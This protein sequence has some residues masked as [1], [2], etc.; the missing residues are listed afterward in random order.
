MA[1]TNPFHQVMDPS[2]QV[3][4]NQMDEVSKKNTEKLNELIEKNV[5]FEKDIVEDPNPKES[6]ENWYS[7]MKEISER[8]EAILFET[9]EGIQKLRIQMSELI[10]LQIIIGKS[11]QDLLK[12]QCETQ[13]KFDTLSKTLT[14]LLLEDR[15][16]QEEQD[17]SKIPRNKVLNSTSNSET[18]ESNDSI[19]LRELEKS[20]RS[21]INKSHDINTNKI[22]IK[23][24]YLLNSKTQ[25]DIWLDL[26]KSELRDYNLLEFIEKDHFENLNPDDIEDCKRRVRDI[27]TNRLDPYYHKKILNIYEPKELIEKLIEIKRIECNV[28]GQTIR[29]K[30]YATKKSTKESSKS[31]IDRFDGLVNEY[32]IG[33]T[34]KMTEE[35]KSELF[36][37]NIRDACPEFKASYFARQSTNNP[38][39]YEEMKN[40]LL[41]IEPTKEKNTEKPSEKKTPVAHL[42]QPV[43]IAEIKCHR[44]TKKGHYRSDCPLKAFNLWFCYPCNDVARHTSE[45]CPNANKQ[46][47]SNENLNN[48]KQNNMSTMRGRERGRGR[49]TFR[50]QNRYNPYNKQP[51]ARLAGESM[52]LNNTYHNKNVSFIADSGATEHIVKNKEILSDFVQR[53]SGEI[54]C[55]NKNKS[56]NIKIN[57]SGK[58][59]FI[60]ENGNEIVLWNV[61]AANSI[62]ENLLSLRKFADAGCGVYLDNTE[63]KI[64]DKSN[65]E[66]FIK[67]VYRKPNWIV[68]INSSDLHENRESTYEFKARIT[69]IDLERLPFK[70]NRTRSDRP[71][72]TVHT[73]TM[74]PIS[75]NSF[76]GNNRWI[77]VFIDDFSRY[78]RVY[79][80]K[81]KTESGD[82]LEDFLKHARNLRGKDEKLCYIRIAGIY[83]ESCS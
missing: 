68:T 12:V 57:G 46:Y 63:L 36:F 75:P 10:K 59:T 31:F 76:P 48:N 45:Q 67:G 23:R 49:G 21:I 22:F 55:A 7:E 6:E 42:S 4:G 56:A 37:H 77:I 9:N 41:Q 8:K 11:L 50:G 27:V 65:N 1:S 53:N 70:N 52:F 17:L 33:H 32:D 72:H 14:T 28:T 39:T 34:V 54:K 38:L 44:C 43:D 2:T 5:H 60:T 73:D 74:G 40:L 24:N 35:E 80:V 64:F 81:N 20:V 25:I 79:C 3:S 61:L 66:I 16:R 15:Q 47:V 62:A 26:L 69:D 51:Q 18:N 83:V 13:R 29:E 78:A 82:C 71:L 30:L 19:K 58:L